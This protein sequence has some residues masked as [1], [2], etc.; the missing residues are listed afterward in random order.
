MEKTLQDNADAMALS[1]E[2]IQQFFGLFEPKSMVLVGASASPMKWGYR[3]LQIILE[4]GYRGKLF[5]VNPQH[6]QW[7]H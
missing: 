7:M 1:P 4:R 2:R 5:A 3:I 6:S